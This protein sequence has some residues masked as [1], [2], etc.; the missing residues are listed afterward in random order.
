M[1]NWLTKVGCTS[2]V[3]C[4]NDQRRFRVL[5]LSVYNSMWTTLTFQR[6]MLP[7]LGC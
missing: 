1:D 4:E 7:T 6:N 3:P 5:A 2:N